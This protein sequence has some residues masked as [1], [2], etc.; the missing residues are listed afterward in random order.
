MTTKRISVR[1][2]LKSL[3]QKSREH[4]ADIAVPE[5]ELAQRLGLTSRQFRRL[6]RDGLVPVGFRIGREIHYRNDD[7]TAWL[8][9]MPMT[10]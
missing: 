1:K 2:Y 8:L 5:H 9:R 10:I 7:I 6:R 3:D 4:F